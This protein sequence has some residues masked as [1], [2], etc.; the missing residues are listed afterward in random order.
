VCSAGVDLRGGFRGGS[1]L[2]I[3]KNI[4]AEI[5]ANALGRYLMVI[6]T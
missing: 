4:L 3:L 5:K 6:S 1:H 2:P